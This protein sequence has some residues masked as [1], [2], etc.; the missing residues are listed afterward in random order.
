MGKVVLFWQVG[1]IAN[2]KL[3]AFLSSR[4]I[5]HFTQYSLEKIT[6]FCIVFR[7][8]RKYQSCKQDEAT[9]GLTVYL[10]RKDCERSTLWNLIDGWTRGIYSIRIAHVT[11]EDSDDSVTDFLLDKL[12]QKK[13]N[14][15]VRPFHK[16]WE[17]PY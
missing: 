12:H 11:F 7:Y 2:V 5:K 16:F 17:F 10:D 3:V 4:K 13:R 14:A 15:Q 1:L 6:S 8:F 9:I